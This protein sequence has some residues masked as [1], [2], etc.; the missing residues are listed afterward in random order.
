MNWAWQLRLR[1]S[2]KLVLMALA[3]AAD[4]HGYCW[5]SIPTLSTKTCLDERSVQRIIK[6]MKQNGII[7]VNA[8]YRKDGSPTSNKYQ[9]ALFT[10]GDNLS[11]P[12]TAKCQG[13]VV[14][15]PPAGGGDVTQTTTESFNESK[16]LQQEADDPNSTGCELIYPN[17]LVPQEKAAAIHLVGKHSPEIA[18]ALL[19]ELAARLNAQKIRGSPLSYLRAL[20]ERA[21]AGTFIPEAGI[22]VGLAR[23]REKEL[24][25]Q[26]KTSPSKP[27]DPAHIPKHLAAIRK[28]LN[29]K[30]THD[31]EEA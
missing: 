3:D 28:A 10:Y 9:L 21:E 2:T 19:D 14:P 15:A 18:Q 30:T 11:P 6:S 29:M 4:D 23:E 5:P 1:P 31:A 26:H 22:R 27:T 7:S 17:Q 25:A 13:E 16:P 8:R 20:A 24:A 12:H